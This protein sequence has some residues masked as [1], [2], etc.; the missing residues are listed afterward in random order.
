[1]AR[2]AK[3]RRL[4]KMLRGSLEAIEQRDGSTYY[5]DP[6]EAF[7]QMFDFWA[8]SVEADYRREPRPDPP[9]C[10]AAVAKARNRRNALERV[11]QGSS[12]LPI[13]EDALVEHGEFIPRSLVAGREYGDFEGLED[14]SEP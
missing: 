8:G 11:M 1:M 6:S 12:F 14:L 2:R 9:A 4:Q 3:L 5:F 7:G 13:D 10:L